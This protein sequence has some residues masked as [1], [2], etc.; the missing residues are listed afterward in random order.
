LRNQEIVTLTP[1][2]FDTLVALIENS[3][4]LLE[5]GDL[6]KSIWR[7]TFVDENTLSSNIST[8]RKAL[9]RTMEI[10]ILRRFRNW[11]PVHR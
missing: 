4:H 6:M 3:G 8:L 7:D 10:N 5:K 1:K 2:A 9:A 11:L